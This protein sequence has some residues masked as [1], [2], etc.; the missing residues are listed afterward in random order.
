MTHKLGNK[1]NNLKSE[2]KLIEAGFFKKAVIVDN[3]HPY[4]DL[5]KHKE[6]ALVVNKYTDWYKHCKYLLN[7]PNAVTDL[8]E[9]LYETVQPYHIKEVNKKRLKF[10]RDVFKKQHIDSS[11]G[12][13]G[14]QSNDK[15]RL[16]SDALIPENI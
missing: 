16:H 3:V 10:Y 11:H 8:G 7:N 12:R 1:F 4:R 15:F 14:V 9:A 13:S 2:L 5:I 6:N